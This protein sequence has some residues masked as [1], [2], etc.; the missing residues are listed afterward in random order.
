MQDLFV[1]LSGRHS[2][3]VLVDFAMGYARSHRAIVSFCLPS[4]GL[5]S[6]P[7]SWGEATAS[8][9]AGLVAKTEQTA[10]R[11]AAVLRQRLHDANIQGEARVDATW[12]TD[13][14]HAMAFR[15]HFADMA[16][17]VG[18]P[19]SDSFGAAHDAF[20]SLLFE[21]GRPV[22]AV[23][24]TVRIPFSAHRAPKLLL[25]WKPTRECARACS[26]A[27][28]AFAPDSVEVLVVG[29]RPG[30]SSTEIAGHLARHDIEVEVTA[31]VSEGSVA[32]AIL[33]QASGTGADVIVVGGYGHARLREWVLGGTTRELFANLDRP[34][35][36]SH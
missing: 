31:R 15:G 2:D 34:V 29:G 22:L 6:V 21:S 17:V 28:A 26:D 13:A 24:P 10:E 3:G 30:E 20:C 23:P 1:P 7:A 25:A 12:I 27:V 19:D 35:L 11:E 9:L 4:P 8:V 5:A 33:R 32:Q 36:F 18:A 14:A 16:L